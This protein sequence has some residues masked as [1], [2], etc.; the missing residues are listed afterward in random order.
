MSFE[1]LLEKYLFIC[2][3]WTNIEINTMLSYSLH[4]R[5]NAYIRTNTLLFKKKKEVNTI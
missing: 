3:I 5:G 4:A 1:T 2:R